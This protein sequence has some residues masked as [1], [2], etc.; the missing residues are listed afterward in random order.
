MS[1]SSAAFSQ[2]QWHS[3]E[4]RSFLDRFDTPPRDFNSMQHRCRQGG[5]QGED[6]RRLKVHK[7]E[8]KSRSSLSECA[9]AVPILK[10]IQNFRAPTAQIGRFV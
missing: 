6:L 5:D 4:P 3:R 2:V 8:S 10:N 1:E 9:S 7:F